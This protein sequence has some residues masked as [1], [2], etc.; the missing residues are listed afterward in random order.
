MRDGRRADACVCLAQKRRK[1]K[2]GPEL[3]TAIKEKMK[4]AFNDVYKA[5]MNCTDD[6]G[7]KRCELFRE[8]PDRRVRRFFLVLVCA[9]HLC[10]RAQDYPDYYRIILTPIA[11]SQI[12]KRISAHAYKTVSGFRDDV[13]LMFANAKTYNQEDSWVYVDAVEMHKVF[14]AAYARVMGGS[15]LPGAPPPDDALTPAE[16]DAEGGRPLLQ[17]KASSRRIVSDDEY[18]TQTDD[19]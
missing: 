11:L 17:K 13:E 19:D 18:L 16:D 6:T 7:R 3:T 4:K 8:L 12:R 9:K 2:S 14:V 1:T 5:L 15:G 10:W